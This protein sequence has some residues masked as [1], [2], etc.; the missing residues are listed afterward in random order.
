MF[1]V[2]LIFVFFIYKA[3]NIPLTD[4]VQNMDISVV[5]LQ[6]LFGSFINVI[7]LLISV[8]FY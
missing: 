6:N 1:I 2:A 7:L 8:L 5:A 4:A 3:N